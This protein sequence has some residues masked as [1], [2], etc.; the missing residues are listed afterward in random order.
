MSATPTLGTSD[1]NVAA[2]DVADPVVS[3]R[4]L[5]RVV[6][7]W[8]AVVVAGM[9]FYYN[10]PNFS[11]RLGPIDDHEVVRW[12]DAGVGV[13]PSG[14]WQ[15]L[16]STEVGHPG[17]TTRYRPA[18]YAV[19]IVEAWVF[20]PRAGAWYVERT[21]LQVFVIAMIGLVALAV[22]KRA[23]HRVPSR[24]TI[25]QLG[26]VVPMLVLA[27]TWGVV[28]VGLPFW[29]DTVTR[30]GPAELTASVGLGLFVWGGYGLLASR[31][32]GYWLLLAGGFAVAALSK[33]N[34]P[35]LL[36]PAALI[37]VERARRSRERVES[38]AAFVSMVVVTALVYAA[39]L[40]SLRSAGS[41]VY[42]RSVGRARLRAALDYWRNTPDLMNHTTLYLV[43]VVV[44]FVILLVRRRS[45]THLSLLALALSIP[46]MMLADSVF[47]TGNYDNAR[48]LMM[49]NVLMFAEA[50]VEVALLAALLRE[51]PQ[52]WAWWSL[53]LVTVVAVVASL[54]GITASRDSLPARRALGEANR[55]QTAAFQAK[56]DAIVALYDAD[57]RTQFLMQI[58]N[59]SYI[60]FPY[61]LSHYLYD[62]GVPQGQL[63]V[64]LSGER[65][66]APG[67][68]DDLI[69]KVSEN[70][71]PSWR[72][73]PMSLFNPEGPRVCLNL[74][75]P[76]YGDDLRCQGQTST[77]Y[78]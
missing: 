28:L 16:M 73:S 66:S 52:K 8:F 9:A 75:A 43:V 25:A 38:V 69:Q 23:A 20:G 22:V 3:R 33:E 1:P 59:S 4:V 56:L 70:G 47:Y 34:M 51:F 63:F 41:D 13:S 45:M 17:E 18:Y 35:V 53:V 49:M 2:G 11:S 6:I 62:R 44:G 72:T 42:G 57:R 48:Y 30:L 74:G 10:W 37:A 55:V 39:V 14:F 12:R 67:R 46:V 5:P 24:G 68:L 29:N 71:D 19:R 50:V 76:P 58:G 60:E 40:P 54:P 27:T 32:R 31:T 77:T 15:L 7:A 21:V 64:I 26:Y 36:L 78:P 61:S 65:T